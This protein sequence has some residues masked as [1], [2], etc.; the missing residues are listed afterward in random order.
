MLWLTLFN[1][2]YF[3]FEVWVDIFKIHIV[4]IQDWKGLKYMGMTLDVQE[5]YFSVNSAKRFYREEL[6]QVTH[7]VRTWNILVDLQQMQFKKNIK[8]YINKHILCIL[9]VKWPQSELCQD[10]E[11]SHG[12]AH[13]FIHGM[14]NQLN[15]KSHQKYLLWVWKYQYNQNGSWQ[16][17]MFHINRKAIQLWAMWI[18]IFTEIYCLLA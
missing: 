13:W 3:I 12:K 18:F 16:T 2:I 9:E 5:F 4:W 1:I 11:S 6:F 17:L 7:R 8:G 15:T 14:E 10:F